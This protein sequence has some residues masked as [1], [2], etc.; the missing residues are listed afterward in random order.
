[1]LERGVGHLVFMA[2]LS[3]KAPSPHSSVYNATKFGL[4]GFA[5]GLRADLQPQRSRRLDRRTRLHPRRRHVRRGRSRRPRWVSGPRPRRRWAAVVRAIERESV[6]IVVAP[7]LERVLT[8]V[9]WRPGAGDAERV[10]GG[11]GQKAAG[12]VAA[13]HPKDKR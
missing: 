5:L 7:A 2:S 6:E 11:M 1:M 8:H 13:G 9:A 12:E 3:G 4:R 10:G